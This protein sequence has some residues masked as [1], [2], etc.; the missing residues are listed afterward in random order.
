[1]KTVRVNQSV[2]AYNFVTGKLYINKAGVIVICTET[3]NILKGTVLY[4]PNDVNSVGRK[5]DTTNASC[6][7]YEEFH[8]TITLEN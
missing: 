7:T 4:Y 3:E 5:C 6:N 1:M 8:G 2:C